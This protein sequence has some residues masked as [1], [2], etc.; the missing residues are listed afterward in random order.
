VNNVLMHSG[1]WPASAEDLA[2]VPVPEV[3]DSYCPIPYGEIIGQVK[4]TLPRFNFRLDREQYALAREGLQMFGV[5]RVSNGH[6]RD[7]LQLAIGLRS[8]YDKSLAPEL[9]SGTSVF[10]CDNLAF[11]G[12]VHVKRKQTSRSWEDLHFMV[13]EMIHKVDKLFA[14]TVSIYD[15]MKGLA[16]DDTVADHLLLNA[17]RARAF[18]VAKILTVAKEYKREDERLDTAFGRGTAWRLFNAFTEVYKSRNPWQLMTESQRLHS[19]FENTLAIK[20]VVVG[21]VTGE[22]LN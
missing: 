17:A 11:S 20:P 19:V 6:N 13:Y 21:A 2:A 18:P 4:D 7:D 10:V 12:A 3:T 16:I 8:S 9:V 15:Q 14:R 1:S 22:Q 5:I